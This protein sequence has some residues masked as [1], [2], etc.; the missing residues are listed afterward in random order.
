[1][2]GIDVVKASGET[3]AFEPQKLVNSLIRAGA[4]EQTANEILDKIQE[5]LFEGMTTKAIYREAHR[6]LRKRSKSV[7]GRYSLKK[8]IMDLRPSGYPF[9]NF[10]GALLSHRGYDVKVGEIV[11]GKCVKHEVD[12]VAENDH[13]HFMVEC[14]FHSDSTR[15]STVQVPL[16]IHSRFQD[17]FQHYK[18]LPGYKTKLQESWIV[19]NTRFTSEAIQYAECIGIN[20]VSWD[21]P[22]KRSLKDWIDQSGLHPITS[23]QSLKKR[24]MKILLDANIVLCRDLDEQKPLLLKLGFTKDIV[25]KLVRR[26][27]ISAHYLP[28][29]TYFTFIY[30]I[31]MVTFC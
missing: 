4:Q 18:K 11:Q 23:L 27:R 25:N 3:A 8:A 28:R 21:Y 24:E 9:E 14:K 10:I 13:D 19:T 29:L 22:E 31:L 2:K 1:M 17:I 20:L 6:L 16:Y 26:P 5:K 30:L 7:A 15:K 12:V